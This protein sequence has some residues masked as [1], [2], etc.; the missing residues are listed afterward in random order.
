M[1]PLTSRLS[2]YRAPY[3][4]RIF[5]ALNRLPQ[6]APWLAHLTSE[7]L[8]GAVC[9]AAAFGAILVRYRRRAFPP[10]FVAGLALALTDLTGARLLKPLFHRLRP[11]YA[12]PA[13]SFHMWTAAANQGAMPSLHAANAFALAWVLSR[14]VRGSALPAYA[15]AALIAVN[16]VVGGV[17]WPSDILA[18]AAFGTAVGVLLTTAARKLHSQMSQGGGHAPVA[19][20]TQ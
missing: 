8:F 5:E 15:V 10:L 17:H 20:S 14:T 4:L 6:P 12:L 9:I 19:A 18:G 11:C 16:R 2:D 3:D 1:G 7:R 13:G